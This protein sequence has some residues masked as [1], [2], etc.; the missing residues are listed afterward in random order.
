MP[1][2]DVIRRTPAGSV[3]APACP[4]TRSGGT[5]TRRA[6][7]SNRSRRSLISTSILGGSEDTPS[8]RHNAGTHGL[9]QLARLK[10]RRGTWSRVFRPDGTRIGFKGMG[11]G[12]TWRLYTPAPGDGSIQRDTTLPIYFAVSSANGSE[13]EPAH[14]VTRPPSSM[15]ATTPD[16]LAVA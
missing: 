7:T 6:R 12:G 2:T 11:G 16:S 8:Q 10:T 1:S 5:L 15:K 13:R 9:E 14:R 4:H 3:G